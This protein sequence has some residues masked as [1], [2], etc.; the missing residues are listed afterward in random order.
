MTSQIMPILLHASK[1]YFQVKLR[2]F[3]ASDPHIRHEGANGCAD[4][5]LYTKIENNATMV[6]L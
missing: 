4:F 1:M 5:K 6:R 3:A 2:D